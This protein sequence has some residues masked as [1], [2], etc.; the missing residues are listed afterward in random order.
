MALLARS[1]MGMNPK[2]IRGEDDGRLDKGDML[3]SVPLVKKVMGDTEV[4]L[5]AYVCVCTQ[6][7]QTY[8]YILPLPSQ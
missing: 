4:T 6:M 5:S 7:S 2:S 1:G 8:H 3:Q